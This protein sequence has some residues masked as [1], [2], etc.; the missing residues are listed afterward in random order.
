MGAVV[1]RSNGVLAACQSH[2]AEVNESTG[3]VAGPQGCLFSYDA[4]I[5]PS[6]SSVSLLG[7]AS[8]ASPGIQLLI[9]GTG[10]VPHDRESGLE[11]QARTK[12]RV[13]TAKCTVDSSSAT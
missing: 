12:V 9:Q 8:S 11:T 5:T 13:G 1:V 4:S 10:F 7:G 6:I 3:A 2:R